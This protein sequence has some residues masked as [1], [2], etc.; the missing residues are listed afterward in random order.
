MIDREERV[1]ERGHDAHVAY[2]H[3]DVFATGGFDHHGHVADADG[4]VQ[5][6][7]DALERVRARADVDH[8]LLAVVYV[9]GASAV[10]DAVDPSEC[11]V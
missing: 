3:F 4:S 9:P 8:V 11:A 2:E 10:D 5:R 1:A 7:V 6:V